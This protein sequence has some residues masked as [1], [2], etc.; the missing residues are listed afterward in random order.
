MT[1]QEHIG[2][3]AMGD[4]EAANKSLI[5]AIEQI[6]V[7]EEMGCSNHKLTVGVLQQALAALSTR[8]AQEPVAAKPD[9]SWL[10]NMTYDELETVVAF[11][12]VEQRD[13]LRKFIY[14]A[15]QPVLSQPEVNALAPVDVYKVLKR[16]SDNDRLSLDF[17]SQLSRDIAALCPLSDIPAQAGGVAENPRLEYI[18]DTVCDIGDEFERNGVIFRLVGNPSSDGEVAMC[19]EL[20]KVGGSTDA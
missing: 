2:T 19:L 1:E 4:T 5:R 9:L 11:L 3:V 7:L 17:I 10:S 18:P 6:I 14:A 8:P 15:P 12:T 16:A 20:P 13:T